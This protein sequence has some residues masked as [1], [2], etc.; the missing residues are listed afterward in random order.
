MIKPE[1]RIR[2]KVRRGEPL[3]QTDCSLFCGSGTFV[4]GRA[5]F[6]QYDQIKHIEA[7]VRIS[8]DEI[9]RIARWETRDGHELWGQPYRVILVTTPKT[10]LSQQQDGRCIQEETVSF[11]YFHYGSGEPVKVLR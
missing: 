7:T 5:Q 4:E 6:K 10:V 2:E 8:E 1:S 3:I 9:Y 11:E